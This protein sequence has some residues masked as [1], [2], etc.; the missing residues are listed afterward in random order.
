M[1]QHVYDAMQK[2]KIL[3]EALPYIRDYHRKR[4]VIKYGGSAMDRPELKSSIAS[5][6]VLMKLVGMNPVIVHGGGPDITRYMERMGK[7]VEFVDGQRVTD[8][9]TMDI[10]KMV[11]VG[12]IN[13]EIV[14]QINLHGHLAAGVSGED[15]ALIVA[16]KKKVDGVDLGFV[17]QVEKINTKILDDLIE[18][19]FIPVVASVGT[20]GEADSY[21]INADAVASEMAVALAA[22]K[23]IFLTNVQGI[24]RDL[25][26]PES[27]I[28]EL[29]LGQCR[30]M[31]A[32][33]EIGAGMLPKVQAC[34]TAIEG[35]VRRAHILDGT[36]PHALL[37]EVFTDE[38]VG[39]MITQ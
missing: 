6:V 25:D 29:D 21:N 27:L 18:E 11:L 23:M 28:S 5:D 20:S 37:L 3:T 1:E 31:V 39:T 14:S 38:G 15:G 22:D 35:G 36:I 32:G 30:K 7:K 2:A 13:K 17:G 4:V 16:R 8:R 12:K 19:G 24:Y 26:R 33:R 34:I 9:E 10:V